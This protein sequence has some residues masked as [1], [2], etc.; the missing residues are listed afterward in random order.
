[1]APTSVQRERAKVHYPGGRNIREPTF[2]IR[3]VDADG[4][5]LVFHDNGCAL[6][7]PVR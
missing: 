6:Y 2:S 4:D 5:C 1:M 3:S 7:V